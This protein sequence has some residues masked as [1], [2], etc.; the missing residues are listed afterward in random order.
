ML[1]IVLLH[2]ARE[3]ISDHVRGFRWFSWLS[4]VPLLWLVYASGLG[5]YWL[6]WDRLAQF[7]LIATS[8][9]LD[10]L[11][12]SGEPIV[13]NFLGG[14]S[15]TDRLFSL[16]IFL[17][18]GIPLLLLLGMW[19]HIQRI[20]RPRTQPGAAIAIG[21]PLAL[22]ALSIAKPAASQAAADLS[23]VDALLDLDWFYL[24]LFPLLYATSPRVLWQLAGGA[25]L[26]LALLPWLPPRARDPAARVDLAHCNGCGRCFADC[27]Y[28]AVTMRPRTDGRAHLSQAVV[29]PDLCAGCGICAGACPSS[30]PFRR[31]GDVLTG[32]DMPQQSMTEVRREIDLAI[33][34]LRGEAKV[35]VFGC[36]HGAELGRMAGPGTATVRLLCA[37]MLPPA[38]VE[39]ALR[40]G[41]DGVFITGCRDGDCQ[42]RLGNRWTDERLSG[43]REPRLRA[44]VPLQ[45]VRVAWGA[46]ADGAALAAELGRFRQSL[47]SMPAAV[48]AGLAPLKGKE[49]QNG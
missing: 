22:L 1:V 17:H 36:A 5:G 20:S 13:R 14:G 40:A 32:I 42:Y 16:L 25:T 12:L 19:V 8:E 6:V 29:D 48:R 7:S 34:G 24:G 49:I 44:A 46:P 31:A 45:L 41:A 35:V 28:A 18:I 2:L 26:L 43:W 38:F 4:G 37:G 47:A 3:W 33:G 27:P 11:P 30:T 21:L 10:W 15:V 39:Y 9:W 23:S